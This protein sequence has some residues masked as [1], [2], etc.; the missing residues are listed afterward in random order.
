MFPSRRFAKT[1]SRS[2]PNAPKSAHRRYRPRLEL[3]EDRR[4]PA[5]T[6][7]NPTSGFWDDGANW[8]TGNAPVR[9]RPV[10][11]CLVLDCRATPGSA[12]DARH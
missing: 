12:P 1:S 3:L 7:I 11:F 2:R 5:V 6:W 10:H 4:V 9:G 8:S